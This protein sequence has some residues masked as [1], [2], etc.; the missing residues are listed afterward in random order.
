MYYDKILTLDIVQAVVL[1]KE[2]TVSNLLF[3]QMFFPYTVIINICVCVLFYPESHNLT[4][5]IMF[6]I[7]LL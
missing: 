3:I 4:H 5:E 2:K 7:K 6:I 1:C